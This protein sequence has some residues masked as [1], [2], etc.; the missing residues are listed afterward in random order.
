MNRYRRGFSLIELMVAMTLGIIVIGG[1]ITVFQAQ[2]RVYKGA[3]A[4]ARIQNADNA[5]AAIIGASLRDA[6]FLGCSSFRTAGSIIKTGSSPLVYDF[7]QPVRG[8]EASST[9][10]GDSLKLTAL[11]A[12][13][14][15]KTGDWSPTL[16]SSL[17]GLVESGSD[18]LVTAGEQPGSQP[19]P[20]SG[21]NGSVQFTIPNT[22][23]G[24]LPA[25]TPAAIS[26]CGKS[27]VFQVTSM[28]NQSNVTVVH[29]TNGGGGASPGNSS[30]SLSR[31]YDD[32]A[33]FVP[34]QQVAYAVGHGDGGQS[35]L[36]ALTMVNGA[37]SAQPL[38]A[39]VDTMQVLYGIGAGGVTT[40]YVGADQVSNWNQVNS[41]R[42]GLL[43]EGPPGSGIADH[44][45]TQWDV[46]GTQVTVP[47]D[48]RLRHVFVMTVNLRNVTL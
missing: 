35:T 8:Y 27:T 7:S 45:P 25:G 48:T 13:N 17:S 2:R 29:H 23:R 43:I 4:Q 1:V 5:A 28:S 33:Q 47:E 22:G 21:I 14:S 12:A 24:L 36:Y 42:V 3:S 16:D 10:V 40:Q 32:G 46:L 11:D 9:G 20:A 41:V 30:G 34:L 31:Q 39:G 37:W 19:V 26:D 44:N 15:S 38:I 18:V 6:G